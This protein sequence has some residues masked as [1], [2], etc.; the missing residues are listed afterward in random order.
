MVA[1][2]RLSSRGW[3]YF[4]CDFPYDR[5]GTIIWVGL[6]FG[7]AYFLSGFP[8]YYLAHSQFRNL[9][10]I[11]IADFASS[12]GISLLIAMVNAM[13]VDL[14]MLPLFGRSRRGHPPASASIRAALRGDMLDRDDALLRGHPRFQCSFQR[15]AQAGPLAVEHR[16]EAQEQNDKEI[17]ELEAIIDEFSELIDRAL[18]RREPPDL[19]V[20]PETA[21]P[22]GWIS[23][24]PRIE[25]ATLEGQ[26]RSIAPK[27]SAKEW[28]EKMESIVDQPSHMDR[29]GQGADAGG[30]HPLRPPEELRSIDTIRR[31]CSCPTFERS[32]SITRC[33]WCPSASISRSSRLCHGW[34]HSRLTRARSSRA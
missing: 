22:Y 20:W 29:Q 3:R 2:V 31:F 5:G 21:Y 12:L 24:E 18:A 23:V 4:V 8:W 26:V 25:P 28:L 30:K 14:A 19:I 32:T 16:A 17:T 10:L 7:R 27:L 15:R 13:V 34:P 9:Y 6:E 1:A 33:T 11:Q